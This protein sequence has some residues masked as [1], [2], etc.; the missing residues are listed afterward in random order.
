MLL[1]VELMVIL[2][3][4]LEGIYLA[5]TFK[6]DSLPEKSILWL[7]STYLP[8]YVPIIMLIAG[9]VGGYFLGQV[10]WQIVYV[11]KRHW[12][13]D[14]KEKRKKSKPVHRKAKKQ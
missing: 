1:G 3:S 13:W 14:R 10:W 2:H 9:L 4:L 6:I 11:E 5:F 7:F 12:S 8:S